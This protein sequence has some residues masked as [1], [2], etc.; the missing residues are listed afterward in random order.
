MSTPVCAEDDPT[1]RS[2]TDI[3][4][5]KGVITEEEATEATALEDTK[6][7]PG[8]RA[9]YRLGKGFYLESEDGLFSTYLTSRTQLRFT[10][11]DRS[12]RSDEIDFRVRRQ[13]LS[14]EGFALLPELGYKIQVELG[15]GDLQ[16]EDVLFQY[17]PWDFLQG[18]IGQFKVPQGYQELVS[19][20]RLQF[21]ERSEANDFF[22]VNRDRG[23]TLGGEVRE[24]LFSYAVG[25]FDGNGPNERN[26]TTDLMYAARLAS[27]PL[28]PFGDDEA[29]LDHWPDP[30]L[31]F[32][33]SA[34]FNTISKDD[35]SVDTI[36]DSTGAVIDEDVDFNLG[37]KNDLINN[38]IIRGIGQDGL[39]R[40]VDLYLWTINA[41]FKYRG[42]SISS[43]GYVGGSNVHGGGAEPWAYGFY[44]QGGYFILPKRLEAGAQYSWIDP[45]R[46]LAEARG[47]RM[48]QALHAGLS[49]YIFKQALKIQGDF[50][51]IQTLRFD[52]K[53]RNDLEF[54]MQVQF[55]L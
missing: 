3:L 1:E 6:A 18:T 16:L 42:V 51:P 14:L 5:E 15:D 26:I 13:K 23:I 2:L 31:T 55:I 47:I 38:F 24:G 9:G 28:G 34:N 50:G 30:R 39:E 25:V 12:D 43:E 22:N 27:E 21:V 19:S 36:T 17:T 20:G 48:Q 35:V 40:D 45:N 44:V 52:A 10:Y 8:I 49:Y 37:S 11:G 41:G 4:K 53:T 46:T 7:L 32:G 54:R 29:D 33:A